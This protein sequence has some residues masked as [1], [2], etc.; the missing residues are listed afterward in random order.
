MTIINAT[1]HA[2]TI[3]VN[4]K[5]QVFLPCGT[6]ARVSVQQKEVDPIMG[7]PVV[8]NIYGEV[9]D[10]PDFNPNEDIVLV[11]ALVGARLQG[12]PGIYMPDTG[13][14]AVRNEKG[15]IVAVTRLVKS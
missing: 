11:S 15:H 2:I 4:G 3:L 9:E 12:E 6:V 5:E 1:P 14:T 13:P 10:L 7:L 8:E